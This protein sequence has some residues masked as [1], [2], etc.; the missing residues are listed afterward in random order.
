MRRTKGSRRITVDG[1][2]YRWR[3]TGNDGYISIGIWPSDNVGAYIQGNIRYHETWIENGDGSRSSAGDQVIVTN[4]II[5]RIIRHA[6]GRHGYNPGVQGAQLNLKALDG[7]V[8]L[9]DAIRASDE[10]T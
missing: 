3:A 5:R 4:R 10:P 8:S 2:E 7:V 9:D 6:I 1:I